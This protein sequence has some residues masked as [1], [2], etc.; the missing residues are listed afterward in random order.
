MYAS[1]F[2]GA[3]SSHGFHSFYNELIDVKRAN[4]VYILKG[5]PGSGKSSLMKNIA[6]AAEKAGYWVERIFC[7]SDPESHDAV[8]I[9]ELGKALVDGTAPHVVEPVYPLA[10]ERYINLSQ[11]ADCDK[12]SEKKDEI[13]A[14]KDKYSTFFEHVYRLTASAGHIDNELFDIALGGISLEKLHVKSRGI[15]SREIR[16]KGS[17]KGTKHRFASAIS[18]KGYV[19]LFDAKKSSFARTFVIED[20]YGIGHFLLVPI[21]K[22]AENAGFSCIACQNPLKPERTEHL[23]IPELSLS[24]IT[25]TREHPYE[26]EYYRKI[27]IDAMIDTDVL[28]SKKQRIS[29]L[30]KLRASLL[31]DACEILGE[32][33]SVHDE[34]EDLYNPHIRFDELYRYADILTKEI[35]G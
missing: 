17:G 6:A 30:K 2:L 32:A 5:G 4:A 29:L 15:I 9:P 20:T 19:N 18:P 34:L 23:I 24:F 7:S 25:S 22:A 13:I 10:V 28:R 12:I 1:F 3:N 8:I 21:L 27:R 16:G 35:L 26:H 11:F 31:D 33:K 14:V